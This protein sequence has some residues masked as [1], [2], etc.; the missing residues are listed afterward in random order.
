MTEKKNEFGEN[1]LCWPVV[2]QNND[3]TVEA[4]FNMSRVLDIAKNKSEMLKAELVRA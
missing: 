1:S 4:R 2:S 3:M